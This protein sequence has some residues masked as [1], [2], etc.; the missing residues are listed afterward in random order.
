MRWL[1]LILFL[2]TATNSSAE[3]INTVKV[4]L[5]LKGGWLINYSNKTL[6]SLEIIS[7]FYKYLGDLSPYQKRNLSYMK[8][9]FKVNFYIKS[10]GGYSQM[11][12]EFIPYVKRKSYKFPKIKIE[13]KYKDCRLKIKLTSQQTLDYTLIEIP[14]DYPVNIS[15]DRKRYVFSDVAV[16]GQNLISGTSAEFILYPLKEEP[17]Y[18]V[19]V[20]IT[21]IYRDTL[22]EKLVFYYLKKED[23]CQPPKD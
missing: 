3:K 18:K 6:Y 1:I 21:F 13:I 22:Y 2:F 15:E 23:L 8:T 10:L 11:Q 9:K 20:Q 17:L 14:Q 7:P 16:L 5:V 12:K 19:P 4:S